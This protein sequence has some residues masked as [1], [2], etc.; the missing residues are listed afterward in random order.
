[1]SLGMM[2]M[3]GLLCEIWAFRGFPGK[4]RCLEIRTMKPAVR[5]FLDEVGIPYYTTISELL[6]SRADQAFGKREMRNDG[7][8]R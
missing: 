2:V 5:G 6:S 4:N 7:M 1:L 8:P 3:A